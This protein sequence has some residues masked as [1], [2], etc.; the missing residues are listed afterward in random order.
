MPGSSDDLHKGNHYRNDFEHLVRAAEI[1]LC[2]PACRPLTGLRTRGR[3]AT[4]ASG[5]SGD[6]DVYG[7]RGAETA[8]GGDQWKITQDGQL[9]VQGVNRPQLMAPRPG[10]DEKVSHSVALDWSSDQVTEFGL[11]LIGLEVPSTMQSSQR[12]ENLGVEVRRGM[13]HMTREPSTD[14]APQLVVEQ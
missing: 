12:R 4:L 2:C 9:D 8:V 10:A 7:G 3:G 14:G 5:G 6:D 11:D 1:N 13:Q